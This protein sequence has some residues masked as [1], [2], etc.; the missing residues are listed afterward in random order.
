MNRKLIIKKI[1]GSKPKTKPAIYTVGNNEQTKTTAIIGEEDQLWFEKY[2]PKTISE[3]CISEKKVESVNNWFTEFKNKE[4]TFKSLLFCGPPGLGK[5]SYAHIILNHH[6]YSVKEYNAS[7]LRGKNLVNKNMYDLMYVSDVTA[8]KPI[9]IIMDEVDGMST[10]DRGGI[11]ELLSFIK[12]NN[13]TRKTR[14]KK[15]TQ[16]AVW[17]PPVI[18]ICNTG[19]IKT[20]TMNQLKKNCLVVNF[21]KPTIANINNVIDRITKAEGMFLSK[22]ARD[23][24]ITYAQSD[25]RRLMCLLQ[26]LHSCYGKHI[27]LS[28]IKESY[29]IFCQKSQD[30]H[31]TDNIKRILNKKLPYD[32]VMNVYHRDKSK[33]PMVMHQNYINAVSAQKTKPF[34]RINN[35]IKIIQS[36]V[37][38]DIVEKTMYNTQGWHLQPIQGITCCYIPSYHINKYPKVKTI[39]AAWTQVL[40]TSSHT[41]SSMKKI[42]ELM[43]RI[44]KKFSYNVS[45]IQVLGEMI[46]HMITNQRYEE[47]AQILY[48][49]NLSDIKDV[50]KL[51][52]SVKLTDY[53]T[54]WKSM[55]TSEKNKIDAACKR[56]LEENIEVKEVSLGLKLTKTK[57]APKST[58]TIIK[59]SSSPVRKR[60]VISKKNSTRKVTIRKKI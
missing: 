49:Y 8:Q 34:E 55:S 5:T 32:Q 40:G 15:A 16:S 56:L 26:H 35:A 12:P 2:R 60:V 27:K 38:S 29:H 47:A 46:L 17:G 48:K 20:T 33:A 53:G 14:V 10:G 42:F 11:E 36:L 19:N 54:Q 7:E 24:I 3:L 57:L 52:S 13:K 30:L 21:T 22:E 28:D 31:V 1:P 59:K 39:N 51:L 6:G 25:Y 43:F 4:S 9:G 18:C 23:E 37:D 41:K 58:P 44:N 45:D 50:D